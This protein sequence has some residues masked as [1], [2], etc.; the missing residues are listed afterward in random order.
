MRSSARHHWARILVGLAVLG[1]AHWLLR[2]YITD[3][4]YIHLRYAENFL[5]RG[6]FAF[7]PGEASYGATSPLWIFGLAGL[8]ALGLAG[9]TAAWTLGL[10]AGAVVVVVWAGLLRRLPFPRRWRWA[11][12]LLGIADAWFLRWTVSGM[13]TPLAAAALLCL[14]WPLGSRWRPR[15]DHLAPSRRLFRRYLAWGVAAG[16]AGLVRPEFFLLGPLALL[17]LLWSEYMRGDDIGGKVGRHQAR[18]QNLLLAVGIGW[19]ASAGPWLLYA[20]LTFG[21]FLPGTAAA[22]SNAISLVPV[23]VIGYLIRS[24]SQL[25]VTQGLLWVYL[26]VIAVMVVVGRR[27][28]EA[29][30]DDIDEDEWDDPPEFRDWSLWRAGALVGI[31]LTWAAVVIGGYAVKQVWVISRYLVPLAMPLLITLGVFTFWLTRGSGPF[32]GRKRADREI[33]AIAVLAT[34]AINA[35]VL[36]AQVRPHART[37]SAGVRECYL[38]LGHR[39]AGLAQQDDVVAALDIG[40]LAYGSD[41]RVLDLMGLVSPQIMTLGREMGFEPMVK[42]GRWLH[43]D[44]V[45][46]PKWF[47]DRTDGPPRWDGQTVEGVRFDLAETCTIHGVGLREAQDWTVALYRLTPAP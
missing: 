37:F 21:R 2:G 5:E 9:E 8:L 16:L 23:E 32:T 26:V 6:E 33:A 31:P 15:P 11:I 40:A 46:T 28:P 20:R 36:V 29:E 1:L 10:I 4:T 45:P 41:L 24:L 47:V 42:S 7:N 30:D 38:D 18:P 44:D 39:L 25:F 12:F 27:D 19:L 35:T 14:L 3:D 13:E 22:K 17:W 43:V 34:L